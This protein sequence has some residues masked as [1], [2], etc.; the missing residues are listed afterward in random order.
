M[1]VGVSGGVAEG[2]AGILV[3][4]EEGGC[5]GVWGVRAHYSFSPSSSISEE[6]TL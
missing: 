4:E 3:Q 6:R 5:Q 2:V 1:V